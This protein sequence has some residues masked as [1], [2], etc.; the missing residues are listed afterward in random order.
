MCRIE[1]AEPGGYLATVLGIGGP[2]LANPENDAAPVLKAFVP[3]SEPLRIGQIIPAT[4]VCM[5]GNKALMTFAYMLGTTERVQH[6][7][8]PDSENAFAIWVDSYPSSQKLRRA[9]D[10]IMPSL[11]GKLLHELT[12]K[13]CDVDALLRPGARG[14]YRDAQGTLRVAQIAFGDAALSWTRSR[15]DLWPQGSQ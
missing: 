1:S 9:V 11:S 5:H 2:P 13:D 4:F 14:I 6:S 15:C 8:A 12:C 7:T 3:S 10:I